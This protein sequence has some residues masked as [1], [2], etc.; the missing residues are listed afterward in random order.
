MNGKATGRAIAVGSSAGTMFLL[1]STG[2]NDNGVAVVSRWQ[3]GALL[4]DDPAEQKTVTELRIDY[5]SASASSVTA[6]YSRDNGATF[7]GGQ[8]VPMPAASVMSQGVAYPYLAAR[9]PMFEVF[10]QGVRHRV[11][12]FQMT[13]LRGGR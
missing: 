6:Q 5:Q 3:S 10:T 12:R 8:A 7:Q 9:Y 1:D 2:T 4:G 11:A 13:F